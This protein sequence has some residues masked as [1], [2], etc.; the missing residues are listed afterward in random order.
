[1]YTSLRVRFPEGRGMS[2]SSIAFIA[3]LVSAQLKN[4]YSTVKLWMCEDIPP[5]PH[6]PL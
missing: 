6:A 2:F 5:R 4:K 1:M 3:T